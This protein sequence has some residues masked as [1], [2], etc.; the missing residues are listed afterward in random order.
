MPEPRGCV[1][2]LRP[3]P[4]HPLGLCR[5]VCAGPG[6][7]PGS[8]SAMP[9]LLD[10]PPAARRPFGFA[11]QEYFYF[12]FLLQ[13]SLPHGACSVRDPLFWERGVFCGPFSS[14]SAPCAVHAGAPVLRGAAPTDTCAHACTCTRSLPSA[15][16]FP[17]QS[18]L[19]T[20]TT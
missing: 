16:F 11:F 5:G 3:E 7:G 4:R 6:T 8:L 1:T 12:A 10:F 19:W 15:T 9:T 18:A 2:L 13:S 17:P 20:M 14:L